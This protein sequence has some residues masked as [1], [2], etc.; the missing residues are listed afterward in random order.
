MFATGYS[1]ILYY[2]RSL[3]FEVREEA[4]VAGSGSVFIP[5]P[6]ILGVAPFS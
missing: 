1:P 3:E 6:P 4:A 5:P 2:R